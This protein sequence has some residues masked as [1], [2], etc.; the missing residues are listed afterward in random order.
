MV[1]ER[2]SNIRQQDLGDVENTAVNTESTMSVSNDVSGG[3][4]ILFW[5]GFSYAAA[6]LV[7]LFCLFREPG[8]VCSN[9]IVR[10]FKID[11]TCMH[12]GPTRR[13]CLS[14]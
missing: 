10:Q 6:G 11:N 1:R 9:Y 2:L 7:G 12:I 3:G 8:S 13:V 5:S 14:R 4:Y